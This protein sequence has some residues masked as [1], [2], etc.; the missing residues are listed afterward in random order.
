MEQALQGPPSVVER[1]IY[2]DGHRPLVFSY[3]KAVGTLL[4]PFLLC[5][6]ESSGGARLFAAVTQCSRRDVSYK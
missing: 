4:E 5:R 2:E 6:E 3:A 1:P